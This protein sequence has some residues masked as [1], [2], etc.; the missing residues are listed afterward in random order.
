MP[1]WIE[2][3]QKLFECEIDALSMAIKHEGVVSGV[4]VTAQAIPD[5]TVAV[6][7]GT[8][9]IASA[10]VAVAAVSSLAIAAADATN[11]R[12]DI[13]HVGSD[14]VVA[15]TTGTAAPVPKPPALPAGKVLLS[16]VDVAAGDTAI[17]STEIHDR[18][19]TLANAYTPVNKAGD[20][21]TGRTTFQGETN[22]ALV[23]IERTG[24]S[25]GA[26]WI[27][28]F[29]GKFQLRKDDASFTVFS[30]IDPTTGVMTIN[31][32]TVFHTGNSLI[33]PVNLHT[34]IE[35]IV[36]SDTIG[37][38][39][40]Q[41]HYPATGT[42]NYAY[43]KISNGAGRTIQSDDY[44][45]YDVYMDPYYLGIQHG[46]IEFDFTDATVGRSF[47]MPDQNGE[48]L[49]SPNL[50]S[51]AKGKWYHRRHSLNAVSGKVIAEVNLVNENNNAG[52][53]RCYYRNIRI[54]DGNGNAR[55]TIYENGEP[56]FNE[57]NY[58]VGIDPTRY[59]TYSRCS[60][61]IIGSIDGKRLEH[62]TNDFILGN[63]DWGDLIYYLNSASTKYFYSPADRGMMC[64]TGSGWA[65]I[66]IRMP[67]DPDSTYMVRAKIFKKSGNG[68]IYIG[69]DSLDSNYRSLSTD[70]AT[71][72][73]Y[74]GASGV[75]IA[76]GA[77]FYAQGFIS[78]YNS[79]T[80]S[81]HTKF[82]PE[83]KYFDLVIISNYNQTVASETVW[84]WLELRRMPNV[85]R[86]PTFS[87]SDPSGL[88]A[89]TIWLRTDL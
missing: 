45:E 77:T 30:E 70:A 78:G 20:V 32:Q 29:S 51:L 65:T 76:A 15:A 14:G 55:A 50:T 28:T 23:K 34:D 44:L 79:T 3:G 69:A 66:R 40:Y 84:Q 12:K 88:T 56:Q 7:A 89:G 46:G 42:N 64:N 81:D 82:D 6:A 72:Y 49:H 10:N 31:G 11:P 74:F 33:K 59:R 27:G 54:T 43:W 61:S 47:S 4:G 86:V 75:S 57:P 85:F 39:E 63:N 5:M 8:I 48:T 60:T 53:Y 58:V 62:T 35:S 2:D 38:L 25:V 80:T 18:R 19:L 87:G 68:A 22:S 41:V 16:V 26:F 52:T 73:N 24:T 37:S 17:N 21:I 71:A 67:V 1:L 36:S 13:V 9:R 83:A